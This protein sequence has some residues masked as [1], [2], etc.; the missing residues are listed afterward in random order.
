M[1]TAAFLRTQSTV[2]ERMRAGLPA[3]WELSGGRVLEAAFADEPC[4][5]DGRIDMLFSSIRAW[6]GLERCAWTTDQW[7][8]RGSKP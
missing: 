2:V 3:K 5:E 1:T 8:S 7:T 4:K 6:S